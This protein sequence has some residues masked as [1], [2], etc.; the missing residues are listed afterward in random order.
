M[1]RVRTFIV[2]LSVVLTVVTGSVTVVGYLAHPERRVEAVLT[3]NVTTIG[4]IGLFAVGAVIVLY[5]LGEF[6]DEPFAL[7]VLVPLGAGVYYVGHRYFGLSVPDIDEPRREE[8][9]IL[10]WLTI[11]YVGLLLVG[12]LVIL[13]CY[14][15]RVA[16]CSECAARVP[17]K[18]NFCP[19][20]G[21]TLPADRAVADIGSE[22]HQG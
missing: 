6:L 21:R 7:V 3:E 10:G 19:S 13:V 9:E 8:L 22:P 16:T 15:T 18:A 20:C 5:F 12:G 2:G 1:Y 17:R 4:W 11:G 14:V